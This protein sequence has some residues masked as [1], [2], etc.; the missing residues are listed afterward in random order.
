MNLLQRQNM[1]ERHRDSVDYYGYAPESLFWESRALQTLLFKVLAEIGV[2]AG[3]SLLDVGCG[4]GDLASWFRDAGIEVNYTGIDL[5]SD[6]L[7][8]GHSMNPELKLLPGELFD[9]DWPARS[10][11]WVLLS[12]TLNWELGDRG[13]YTRRAIRRMFDLC[14]YGVAFNMNN[15]NVCDLA[16]LG[17]MKADDPKEILGF[18]LAITPNCRCRSDYR[19][20]D[21]TIYMRR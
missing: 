9:F 14:R 5:S 12:G 8:V 20:D 18:C 6:I 11:D 3:D 13:A 16:T 7:A 10:F 19:A 17:E 15:R 2:S 21:F 1:I 4:F